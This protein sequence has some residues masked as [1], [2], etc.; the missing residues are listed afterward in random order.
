MD[1]IVI[2]LQECAKRAKPTDSGEEYGVS[3]CLE[4]AKEIESCRRDAGFWEM[5]AKNR[6]DELEQSRKECNQ[7]KA[8]LADALSEAASW[9]QQASARTD[10]V[11]QFVQERDEWKK[12]AEAAE[13]DAARY[14]WLRIR[15]SDF[16]SVCIAQWDDDYRWIQANEADLDESIDAA[17]ENRES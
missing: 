14:R 2:R 16:P 11:V 4:A 8:N 10:D 12:R 7:L 15:D 17:M 13:K 1:D 5:F 9:E 3:V 6:T